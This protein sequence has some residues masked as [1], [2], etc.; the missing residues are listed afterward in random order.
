MITIS[1]GQMAARDF[2]R[3]CQ[4]TPTTGGA[5]VGFILTRSV[6]M[7]TKTMVITIPGRTPPIN[8][9]P[10]L[11]SL[12]MLYRTMTE[13]GGIIAAR[14][15]AAATDPQANPV[16][17]PAFF[18][19]GTASLEKTTVAATPEP[20]IAAKKALATTTALAIPPGKRESHF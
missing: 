2:R 15:P 11:A 8:S 3:S 19:S 18:I 4:L 5:K 10:R 13:L 12:S 14:G 6:M 7:V 16:S 9:S 20:L 17:Y 1:T